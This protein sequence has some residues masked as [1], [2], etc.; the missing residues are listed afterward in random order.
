MLLGYHCI[1]I[2]NYKIQIIVYYINYVK[3]LK[4]PSVDLV[5]RIVIIEHLLSKYCKIL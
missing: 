4:R 2:N 5:Y 1:H 3:I